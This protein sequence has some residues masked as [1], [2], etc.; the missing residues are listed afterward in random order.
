MELSKLTIEFRPAF[1]ELV[2]VLRRLPF[3]M[4]LADAIKEIDRLVTNPELKEA[5]KR[6]IDEIFARTY[7]KIKLLEPQKVAEKDRT[8]FQVANVAG[9][10]VVPR[11]VGRLKTLRNF[12]WQTK[13]VISNNVLSRVTLLHDKSR[14]SS[15]RYGCAS[16]GR[17]EESSR[18]AQHW[19]SSRRSVGP[20]PPCFCGYMH[21]SVSSKLICNASFPHTRRFIQDIRFIQRLCEL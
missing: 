3:R 4:Q 8:M 12:S 14:C 16:S 2:V 1:S 15:Q 9:G 11:I 10:D 18:S 17:M 5:T 13:V 6:V 21:S 20:S 19:N 7:T